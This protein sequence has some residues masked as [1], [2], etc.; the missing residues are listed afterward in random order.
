MPSVN[1]KA[2]FA[3]VLAA[4]AAKRFG[5]AKQLATLND[6]PLVRRT[7]ELAVQTC[8]ARS[9]LVTGHAWQAVAGA[10]GPWPGYLVVNEQ[11]ERGIGWSIALGTRVVQHLAD[12]IVIL[13]ADQPLLEAADLERLITAWGG[14]EQEIIASAYADIRGAPT[15]FAR[16]CFPRLASLSGDQGARSLFDDPDFHLRDIEC[17]AAATDIDTVADLNRLGRNARN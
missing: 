5:S 10:A 2:V 9:I 15:L 1:N 16:G 3:I 13:L 11:Y 8:G 12:A 14:G 7:C 17:E 4:G 6:V